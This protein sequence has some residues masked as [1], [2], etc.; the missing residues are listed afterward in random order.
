LR[1]N[2]SLQLQKS[3]H[4][5]IKLYAILALNEMGEAEGLEDLTIVQ[6]FANVFLE[7]LPS[8]PP[9]RELDFTIDLKGGTELISR[10]PDQMSMPEL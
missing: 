10:T 9:K 2:S 4:K 8:L 6:E 5:G 3:M 1:F 7:D